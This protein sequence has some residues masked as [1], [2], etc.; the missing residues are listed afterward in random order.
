MLIG[1]A[2]TLLLNVDGDYLVE[3]H[4]AIGGNAEE[5]FVWYGLSGDFNGYIYLCSGDYGESWLSADCTFSLVE[6]D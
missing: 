4:G 5:T 6:I 2:Q 3:R 1:E